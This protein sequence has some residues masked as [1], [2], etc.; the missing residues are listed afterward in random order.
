MSGLQEQVAEKAELAVE[1]FRDRSGDAL[2]YSAASLVVVEDILDEGSAYIEELPPEQ[3]SAIVKLLGSY[4]LEVGRRQFDGNYY[5]HDERDQPVLV[6]GEPEYRVA[7][8][9]FDKVRGRLAGDEAD[10]IPF[11]Y[12]GFA[13]RAGNSQAGDDV[14]FV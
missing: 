2:D 8:M 5:W 9:T 14:L 3:V 12:Q 6:V 11:F 7:M 10:N 4:V 1:Q 13:N